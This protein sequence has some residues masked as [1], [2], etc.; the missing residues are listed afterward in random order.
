MK[1]QRHALAFELHILRFCFAFFSFFALLTF[2]IA[3]LI[4]IALALV[5]CEIVGGLRRAD[6]FFLDLPLS[7]QIKKKP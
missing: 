7:L 6:R 2:N 3:L 4:L 1:N 5:V